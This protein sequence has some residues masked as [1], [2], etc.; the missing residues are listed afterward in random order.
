MRVLLISISCFL[1]DSPR[2]RG[3]VGGQT[4]GVLFAGVLL[5]EEVGTG[6][7]E[8]VVVVVVVVVEDEVGG[9]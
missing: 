3:L 7:D 8:E 6:W 1:R 5:E 9:G 4:A 2:P